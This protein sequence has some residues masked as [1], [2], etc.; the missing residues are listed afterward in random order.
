MAR[1]SSSRRLPLIAVCWLSCALSIAAQPM[2]PEPADAVPAP[3]AGTAGGGSA[4]CEDGV[5]VDDGTAETGYGW[6]PSVI[7]GE[8]VQVFDAEAFSSRRLRSVCVCWLRTRMDSTIDF[9]IVFYRQVMDPEDGERLIPD[10][11]P[12]A[13]FPAS[14][15]VLP[16]G[17]TESFFEVDVRD[18]IIPPGR[19]YIGARWD[20]SRDQFF[21]VCADH[22]EETPAVEVFFRDDRSE[23]EWTSVFETAD[24][25]FRDHRAIMVRALPG[26]LVAIDVPALGAGGSALLAAALLTLAL[27]KLRARRR[28]PRPGERARPDAG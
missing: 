13:V 1:L 26:P 11:L 16:K 25:I 15:E 19:S 14:A 12:Y 3:G 24:P 10:A 7:E 18:V 28:L 27:T 2:A 20:A 21:F 22:S 9:E 6:V 23:G 4:E 5:V 8:Y 17:I